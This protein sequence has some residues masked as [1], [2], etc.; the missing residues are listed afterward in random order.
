MVPL[1]KPVFYVYYYT[2]AGA[3][4]GVGVG[5]GLAV[6]LDITTFSVVEGASR[7]IFYNLPSFLFEFFNAPNVFFEAKAGLGASVF[8]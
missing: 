5:T 1:A 6:D 7:I 8:Y 2:G 4:V 3:G